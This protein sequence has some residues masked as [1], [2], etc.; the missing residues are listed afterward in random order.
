MNCAEYKELLAGYI[1]GLLDSHQSEAVRLHLNDCADCRK[2]LE[3]ITAI[4]NR[5]VANGRLAGQN[6]LENAVMDRILREQAFQLRKTK[7]TKQYLNFWRIFMK[8]RIT[9]LAAAAAIIIAILTAIYFITGKTPSV[10]CCTW[11]ELADRVGQIKTC[12]FRLHGRELTRVGPDEFELS[13]AE[14]QIYTSL[15][16][17]FR[18]NVYTDGNLTMQEYMLPDEKVMISVMPPEK[19][20]IRTILTDDGLEK[21]KKQQDPR[22]MVKDLMSGEYTNQGR[23]TIDGVA[24]EG[25][26]FINP[27]ALLGD[28]NTTGMMWIDVK[29]QLPVRIQFENEVII[30]TKKM[31]ESMVMYEFK[32]DVELDTSIFEPNVPPDYTMEA[33]VTMPSGDE[34][35]AIEG[36]QI[37]AEYASGR[38]PSEMK[39]LTVSQELWKAFRE[40]SGNDPNKWPS[41]EQILQTSMNSNAP[42]IFYNQLDQ[43]GKDP[44]YYGKDVTAGDA[45]AVLMRWKISEGQYRVIYGDLT[46]ED[47]NAQQLKEMEQPTGP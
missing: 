27:P 26:K 20:Y 5:L 2:E 32:W 36:L 3:Q 10:T 45:N 34:A 39:S 23:K 18:M 12:I 4:Q 35:S 16:Y 1:E 28:G 33:E 44:A 24:V 43:T 30:G 17:G 38:Y 6:D 9:Q 31:T 11:A 41:E 14:A 22:D 13:E 37:F 40:K 25:I 7:E 47:V 46:I 21:M 19:R 8:N 29:T 42:V 15:E